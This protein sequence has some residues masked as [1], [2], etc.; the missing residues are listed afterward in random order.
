MSKKRPTIDGP[1][2]VPRFKDTEGHDAET[3]DRNN[4]FALRHDFFKPAAGGSSTLLQ[5]AKSSRPDS[6]ASGYFS[7]QDSN[8]NAFP[9]FRELFGVR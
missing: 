6:L 3:R 5:N 4:Q 8:R 1:N 9:K 2:Q 7:W